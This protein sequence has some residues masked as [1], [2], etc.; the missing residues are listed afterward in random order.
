MYP[1]PTSGEF[2]IDI[3]SS[4]NGTVEMAIYSING[5]MVMS[6]KTIQLEEGRNTITQ[7]ISDLSTGIYVVKLTN[8]S[9]EEVV[10][11]QLIKE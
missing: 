2:N 6:P 3:D 5:L 11:K 4:I 10:V 8:S 9:N 7:N 1:N